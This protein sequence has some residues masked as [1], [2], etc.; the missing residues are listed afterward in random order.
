LQKQSVKWS[1]FM[2]LFSSTFVCLCLVYLLFG[3]QMPI[4]L[5]ALT[6]A[7]P[8]IML[9]WL[10]WR[11]LGQHLITWISL[12]LMFSACGDV[13]LALPLQHG[14]MLGLASFACAHLCYCLGFSRYLRWQTYKLSYLLILTLGVG[15]VLNLVL[16]HVGA[17]YWPVM[18][19]M[20]VISLMA[21]SAIGASRQAFYLPLGALLFVVSD[22][23]L[24]I[25]KFV[26]PLPYDR[27]WVMLSYY[28]AQYCLLRG[29]LQLAA[30][31]EQDKHHAPA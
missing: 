31:L 20:C 25:N 23:L 9:A 13:L 11:R 4:V 15:I 27:W 17:L 3:A 7:T 18:V 1:A 29:S 2:L 16:P 28:A 21:L 19:Y 8:I 24:A 26:N 14:F 22:A 6:K 30:T 10:A 5:T 12:A